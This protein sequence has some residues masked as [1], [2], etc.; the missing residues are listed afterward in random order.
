MI[1]T[2]GDRSRAESAGK[3]SVSIFLAR[4]VIDV[5]ERSGV[6][7][8]A[9]FARSALDLRRVDHPDA[10]LE[11]EEF[12]RLLDAA[13]ALTGDDALGLHV[14][15]QM[16]A[17]AVDL[18]AHLTAHAPTMR[19]AVAVA[20]QF[21]CLV[22]DGF[23]MATHNEDEEFVVQL[24][25][26]RSTPLHDRVL[27]ELAMGG[28]VRLGRTFVNP[29]AV[30][31]AAGFEHD[32]PDD[33]RE[34]RRVFGENVRFGQSVTSIVFHREDA[35]RAQMHQNAELY[36]LLR[37][38]AERRL[39]RIGAHVRPVVRLSQYVR[40]VAPSRIPDMAKAARQLGMSERSLRRHLLAE[41]T[42]YRSVV[43]SALE[44]SAGR[45]LMDSERTI[46]ETADALGFAGTA[47]FYRAFKR[48]TGMT[49]AQYR[50]AGIN[51]STSPLRSI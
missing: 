46:K 25:F 1:R 9:L 15:E 42:S 2:G 8:S 35:D 4:A 6:S 51:P 10:R 38:E 31:R 16:P 32:A 43:R 3:M 26:A 5:V 12:D 28:L 11:G 29:Q 20:S 13:V 44:T 14:A 40:A 45:M 27:G 33:A 39:Q 22:M 47:A 41:G 7:R 48:W 30:P 18:L 19:E 34:Y 49:P 23:E 37:R 17:G 21:G 24:T 50:R 36:S